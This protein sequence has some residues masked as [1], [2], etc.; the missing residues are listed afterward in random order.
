[1]FFHHIYFNFKYIIIVFVFPQFF[2]IRRVKHDRQKLT[3]HYILG[4]REYCRLAPVSSDSPAS[5]RP[6]ASSAVVRVP[7]AGAMSGGRARWWSGFCGSRCLTAP[8]PPRG[9]TQVPQRQRWGSSEVDLFLLV[10]LSP[11]FPLLF[12]SNRGSVGRVHC[13]CSGARPRTAPLVGR[14]AAAWAPSPFLGLWDGFEKSHRLLRKK[15]GSCQIQTV[16]TLDPT[17][18]KIPRRGMLMWP[19]YWPGI[20]CK[21]CKNLEVGSFKKKFSK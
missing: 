20:I 11:P 19:R 10:P 18:A 13:C 4:Q 17:A 9:H 2:W 6:Q 21:R 8:A 12:S 14:A 3:S 5:P 1:M 7:A 15:A 16:H